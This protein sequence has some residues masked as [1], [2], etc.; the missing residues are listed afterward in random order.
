MLL[1]VHLVLQLLLLS[2]MAKVDVMKSSAFNVSTSSGPSVAR[3]VWDLW[4]STVVVYFAKWSFLSWYFS[5][6]PAFRPLKYLWSLICWAWCSLWASCTNSCTEHKCRYCWWFFF[7]R[8][9]GG[10]GRRVNQ[11]CL[12]MSSSL[13]IYLLIGVRNQLERPS[14]GIADIPGGTEASSNFLMTSQFKC[15]SLMHLTLKCTQRC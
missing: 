10:E 9:G 1:K 5:S 12:Q 8:F 15:C 14:L 11:K 6:G 3:H 2:F 4:I 7:V 13:F